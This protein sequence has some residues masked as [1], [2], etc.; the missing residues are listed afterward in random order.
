MQSSMVDSAASLAAALGHLSASS[1]LISP[2]WAEIHRISI[3]VCLPLRS[4]TLSCI[5]QRMFVKF[6]GY[7]NDD[8]VSFADWQS[9]RI[10]ILL[11]LVGAAKNG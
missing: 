1:F 9:E 11:M 10:T 3:S 4:L 7:R 5:L 6:K 8:T 2:V